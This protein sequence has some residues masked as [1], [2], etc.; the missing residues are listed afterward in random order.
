M[1][2]GVLTKEA[3]EEVVETK[4]TQRLRQQEL[5]DGQAAAEWT[6]MQ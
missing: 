6:T 4:I 1:S 5:G 3:F 2:D